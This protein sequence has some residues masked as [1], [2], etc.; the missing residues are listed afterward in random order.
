MRHFVSVHN[1]INILF[2]KCAGNVDEIAMHG[3]KNYK[4]GSK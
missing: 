4:H 1:V 2:G 3:S